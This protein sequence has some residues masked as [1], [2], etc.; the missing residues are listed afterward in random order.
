MLWWSGKKA[1]D[2]FALSS[3]CFAFDFCKNIRKYAL[4]V[5]PPFFYRLVYEFHHSLSRGLS[6]SKRNT[7][8]FFKVVDFQGVCTP[9]KTNMTMEKQPFEDCS[10][11]KRV[12]F[13]LLC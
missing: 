3:A 12:F 10:P 7:P 1:A 9:L 4:D 8:Q 5:Q 13:Q 6:S 2:S 11:L